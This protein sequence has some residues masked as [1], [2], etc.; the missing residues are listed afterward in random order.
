MPANLW[1]LLVLPVLLWLALPPRPRAVALTAHLPEWLLAHAA[2]RRR[3]PRLRG[4]R[5]VLLACA[6]IAAVLAMAG[7]RLPGSPGAR[8]LVVLLDGSASMAADAGAGRAGTRFAAAAAAVRERTAALGPHIAVDLLRCGGPLRRRSGASARA[9]HDLGAPA[10]ALLADLP[11]VA[12]AAAAQPDTAVWTLT[13]GQ[14]QRA[15]PTVGALSLF[16]DAAA[17]AALRE[18]R[19]T[20]HWPLPALQLAIALAY[21]GPAPASAELRVLGACA[22]MPPQTVALQPGAVANVALDLVRTAAG[23]ALTVQ[24]ALPRDALPADDRWQA[25]L[26]PLPAPRIAVL[27]DAEAGPFAHVAAAALAGEVG[28]EVVP[29]AAGAE[30]GLLLVDGGRAPL[31]PG[32]VRALCF[33]SRFDD[34]AAEPWLD[35]TVADWDRSGP[36]TTGLDLSE[37]RIRS[38]FP[39]T[40]PAGEAFLWGLDPHGERVPLAVVAGTEQLASVHFAFRLQDSNLPL[41]PAFPQLLRRAFVRA[42]GAGAALADVTPPPPPG[43]IDLTDRANGPDRPL[44]PFA[45]PDRELAALVLLVGLAA[46]ALRAFVR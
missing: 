21:A 43:E 31:V 19:V 37:L 35:P 22:A 30:V 24:I 14:G 15:L 3:P 41:L 20:D 29:A 2:L 46:L 33:G 4:L 17:N 18:V 10:G 44:P 38:A 26:P 6:C 12:A 27:A 11:A 36:L 40:L 9:L 1:W 28:G 13:D 23:G 25:T 42:F 34:A 16:G 39:A 5:F 8:R 7:P 45:G 32:R